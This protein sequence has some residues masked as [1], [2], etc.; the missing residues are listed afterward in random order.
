M[1]RSVVGTSIPFG[2]DGCRIYLR[3]LKPSQAVTVG[4]YGTPFLVR[5]ELVLQ[6]NN[7]PGIK[8][9]F[10][11]EDAPGLPDILFDYVIGG[12][13]R[14]PRGLLKAARRKLCKAIAEAEKEQERAFLAKAMQPLRG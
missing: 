3:S 9:A 1:S 8:N 6:L 13:L 4:A 11:P 14:N 2:K 7:T 5:K 12:E 10:A